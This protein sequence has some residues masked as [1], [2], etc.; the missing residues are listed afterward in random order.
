[1]GPDRGAG[2]KGNIS[3][4]WHKPLPETIKDRLHDIINRTSRCSTPV[5][6]FFRADD[7]ALVDEPFRRLM[8]IFHSHETPLCLAVVP[9]WLTPNNWSAIQKFAPENPLWCWH[10]HGKRHINYQPEGKKCE[11]GDARDRESISTDLTEGK[12]SLIEIVGNLFYPV[13]TPPWN[14]CSQTTLELLSEMNFAAVSRSKGAKPSAENILPDLAVNI[15]LHTRRETRSDEGWQ[16]LLAEFM[17][18]VEGGRMGIMLHHQLMN[19]AAFVF[20]DL[21]LTY[22]KSQSNV[23]PVTFRELLTADPIE[24]E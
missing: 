19:E 23:S 24:M 3:S 22:I 20:L 12:N 17:V 7:I 14:R 2:M 10:Q 18:A 8:H 9:D 13:F 21:L 11:F 16:N 15:D 6:I 4:I 1:M 5:Q